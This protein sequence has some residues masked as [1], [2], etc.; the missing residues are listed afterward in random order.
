MPPAEPDHLS[1]MLALY[2]RLVE[3]EA[4]EADDRRRESWHCARKAF[5]W[6]HLF[7]WLIVYLTKFLGTA[8]GFYS[9]WG[10]MLLRALVGEIIAV[11]EQE[12]L[13][14]QLRE[15]LALIDP[16]SGTTEEFLQSI[17]TPVRSGMIITRADLTGAARKL[18]LGLRRGERKFMLKSL[19][20]QD[21]SGV[22]DW[23]MAETATW[24]QH[25]Q[26]SKG[27]M[28]GEIARAWEGKTHAAAALLQELKLN[29]SKLE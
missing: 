25:H 1:V 6:E 15:A 26:G 12:R 21:A 11:G 24:V 7:S 4:E 23:L 9:R 8:T 14:L 13:P 20:A 16:R 19:F 10:A 5:L 18:N 27:G 3:L 17:L 28:F 29:A 2:A 22:F